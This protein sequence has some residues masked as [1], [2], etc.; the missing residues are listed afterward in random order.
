MAEEKWG[1]TELDYDEPLQLFDS[2]E[3]ALAEAQ[4]RDEVGICRYHEVTTTEIPD[5][6]DYY[7]VQEF[8]EDHLD[9]CEDAF[10]LTPEQQSAVED[11]LRRTLA[12]ELTKLGKWPFVAWEEVPDTT[13]LVMPTVEEDGSAGTEGD[14]A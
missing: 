7:N 10:T 12:D 4:E 5:C 13:E 14:R 3:E 2:R 9:A 1:F 11:A 8:L 6:F